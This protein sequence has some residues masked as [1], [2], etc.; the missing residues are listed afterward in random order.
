MRPFRTAAFVRPA[1]DPAPL[2]YLASERERGSGGFDLEL[3][4][5]LLTS[6]MRENRE[7]PERITSTNFKHMYWSFAQMLTHHV[8]NGCNL[9]PGTSS[10]A[11]R[12]PGPP[13]KAAPASP[14][15]RR[16]APIRSRFRTA[17][18]EAG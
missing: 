3:R 11:A 8:S 1:G 17:K 4:A 12:P 13:K 2:P 7:A 10:P 9:S 14:R 5:F 18:S 6:G 16:A 15:S